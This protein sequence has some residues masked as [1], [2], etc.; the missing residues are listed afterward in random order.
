MRC[1]FFD[2]FRPARLQTSSADRAAELDRPAD[3]E[4]QHGHVHAAEHLARLA[5]DLRQQVVA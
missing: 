5:A 2:N 1:F 3:A 4:L